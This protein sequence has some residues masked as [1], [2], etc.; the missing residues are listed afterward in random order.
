MAKACV[1]KCRHRIIENDAMKSP[2]TISVIIPAYNAGKYIGDALDS[3]RQQT[4]SDF[5]TI[6]IDDG[7]DDHTRRI[8][9][10]FSRVRYY[11]QANL[12]EA[13]ARNNGMSLAKG[14]YFAFLDADDWYEKGK[15]E[16][17]YTYLSEN[18]EKDI[19]YCDVKIFD[20]FTERTSILH[21]EKYYQEPRNFLAVVLFRQILPNIACTMLRRICFDLGCRFQSG[22]RY[23]PDYDYTIRLL[24]RFT[25]GYLPEALYVYRRHA[26]NIT[27]AHDLQRQSEIETVRA[28]G[29]GRIVEIVQRSTFN[30]RDKAILLSK[31][32]LK[33]GSYARCLRLMEQHLLPSGD[34]FLNLYAGNVLLLQKKAEQ[35]V[36]Y[37]ELALKLKNPFPEALN[38][39]GC[40]LSELGKKQE[41]MHL[42]KKAVCERPGYMDPERNMAASFPSR[43]TLFELREQLT[44]YY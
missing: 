39:L 8:V 22:L 44:R 6:V 19:V 18:P 37:F 35:S 31:I 28:L 33:I 1:Q 26:G 2:I 10:Q 12:G 32:Y 21:A 41:A 23:A 25:M 43:I 15:I 14:D 30:H 36:P 3:L 17:Q 11:Y 34:P 29:T 40:A 5:E 7:S 16:R 38:N 24:K 9:K 4:F 20:E 42:F 13:S 27:N